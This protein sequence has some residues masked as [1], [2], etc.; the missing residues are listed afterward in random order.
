MTSK[1]ASLTTT[2][3]WSCDLVGPALSALWEKSPAAVLIAA[4]G[5]ADL[6]LGHLVGLRFTGLL[7]PAVLSAGLCLVALFYTYVRVARPISELSIY[8]ARWIAF[9]CVGCILTYIAASANR[10]LIDAQLAGFDEALGFDWVAWLGFV[11]DH[12]V[13]RFTLWASYISIMA[14]I[15]ASF[16]FF[17]L[18]GIPDRNEEFLTNAII[19]VLV[20]TLVSAVLPALGA[21]AYFGIQGRT[22]DDIRLVAEMTTLRDGTTT[23]FVMDRMEGIICFP[24]YHAVLAI[25][26][27]Y[28]HRGLR[29][30]TLIVTA[31][32]IWMLV[33]IPS[34]GV[35][36]HYLADEVAGVLTAFLAIAATRWAFP[37]SRPRPVA[38][39]LPT[40]IFPH[41]DRGPDGIDR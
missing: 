32:N 37:A 13:L 9:T 6:I 12:P 16:V 25:L 5:V 7:G 33:S 21:L 10:P 11:R 15:L 1:S 17:A 24:S 27:I 34:E 8:G 28:A 22:P 19:S 4:I 3:I 38:S 26:L 14:Q 40:A 31:L 36:G 39:G 20:T 41:T 35:G 23:N 29:W 30:S 2:L 18:A